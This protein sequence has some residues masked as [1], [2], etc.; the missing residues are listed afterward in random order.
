M[1]GSFEAVAVGERSGVEIILENRGEAPLRF[2]EFE[3][4]EVSDDSAAEFEFSGWPADD[5]AM[6]IYPDRT[7]RL[8][9]SYTPQN[10]T[11]DVARISFECNDPEDPSHTVDFE[12]ELSE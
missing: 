8:L 10:R 4:V 11:P 3:F 5:S 7:A 9:L 2:R 12:P 6:V 1:R